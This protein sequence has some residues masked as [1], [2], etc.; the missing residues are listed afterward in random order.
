VGLRLEVAV[1]PEG[2]WTWPLPRLGL[3]LALPWR[4]E[5][6]QGD[7]RVAWYG[8]GPGEAYADTRQALRVGQYSMSVE[9]MQTPYVFPQENGN[10]LDVRRAELLRPDGTGLRVEGDPLFAL[11]VRRWSTEELEAA[12]HTG[13][14][15]PGDRVWVNLDHAQH[16]IGTASCGPDVLPPY[17]LRAEPTRFALVLRA[18]E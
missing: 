16:G 17:V 9:E 12:R 15:V 4:H 7:V 2:E 13:D 6:R 3:R 18:I 11:T 10:R 5:P 14:L 1:E 8:G